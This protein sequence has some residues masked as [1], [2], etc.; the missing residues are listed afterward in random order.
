MSSKHENFDES[1]LD[2]LMSEAE[3]WEI[4][5]GGQTIHAKR[6]PGR[7]RLLK[8]ITSAVWLSLFIGPYFRYGD[9]QAVLLDIPHRQFHIWNSTVLPQDFWM[10]A[11]VLLFFAILMAVATAMAGRIFCGFFCFQTAWTDVFTW[12]EEKL[13][14]NPQHRRA[15]E[16]APWDFRKIRIKTTKHFLWL[17]ISI[18]TG[19]SFVAWFTDAYQLWL[20]LFTLDAGLTAYVVILTFTIGTYFLAGF[21]REQNC[22][23][24]CPYA[25]IQGVMLDNTSLIPTYDFRR[26]EPRGRIQRGEDQSAKGDC[27]DCKQCIA[28]CPTGVDIRNGSQEGCIMCALCIDACDDI[29]D[30]LGKPRGLVRFE[31]L[32]GMEGKEYGKLLTRPRVWIYIGILVASVAG[33]VYGFSTLDAI[34]LKVIHSRQP[35][36][37]LQSDGSVQ[38]KYTLKVLNKM[39]SELDVHISANGPEGLVLVGADKPV[40]ARRGNVTPRDVFVRVPRKNLSA[41]SIPVVFHIKGVGKD[42]VEYQSDRESVFIGPRR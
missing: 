37:V 19:V 33:I 42:G 2:A 1:A 30:K 31:S 32:D 9:R 35:L 20:D 38:N 23:W 4:N 6:I 25:R 3:H 18:L 28:V 8:W 5:T 13:E 26:G 39:T 27:V 16:K 7:W 29:M 11:L 10:L 15:L 21:M 12:L 14:G 40:T 41:E 34:E 17:V 24:L 22:F 36:Y